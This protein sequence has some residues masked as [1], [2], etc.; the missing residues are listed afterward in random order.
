MMQ[1]QTLRRPAMVQKHRAVAQSL[2]APVG[3]WNA[4]DSLAD[5]APDDA[6]SLVNLYPGTTSVVLRDGF[7]KFAT[8]LGAQV[9]TVMSYE[10]AGTAKLFGI[11]GG[12][13][14]NC[15]A[16]GAV[17][18]AE[19]SGL[20][21]SRWQYVNISTAGGNF[22]EMCNGVDAV[23]T[24]DGSTW[25]D[26]SGNITGVTSSSLIGINLHKN[27]VWFVESGALKAWYLP[28]QSISGAAAV[29]DLRSFCVH[30][31]VLQAI[32]TWTIDAGYGV[33]DL[34]VGVTSEGEVLVYRGTD[35]SS[36]ST[37]ALVGI[38]HIGSPVGRRCMVKYAGDLLIICQDG[39]F[40]MASALQSSRTN[41]R[42]A[43]TDK[44][45]SAMSSAVTSYGA[46][47]GW[48]L[49][50]FP[51][52]NALLL[53]VPVTAGNSQQQYVMNTITKAWC[54]FR[55]WNA[56]VFELYNDDLY[57][58]GNTYVGKAWN[59]AEDDSGSLFIDGLQAFNYFG[60]RGQQKRFTM[61][62]PILAINST[63][64]INA[65]IN[66]NFDQS[67][68]TSAIGTAS[69]SGA[70]WD[71][72]TWDSATWSST[73]SISQSWQGATGV[74]YCG[75]PHIQANLDGASLQWLA[76]DV[77]MEPGGIV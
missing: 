46:N 75:A 71:T 24:Y 47:Y 2:P 63:Q 28:V 15:T 3:G 20:T 38:W 37:W 51:K 29:L 65:G 64:Q 19:L 67:A 8:G 32:G 56:N 52:H 14:Y 22:I 10:G 41:P 44:I 26:Q 5:M 11:A 73:S 58:G 34:W 31:G 4:R 57:F 7:S 36:A 16:G 55:G 76:T 66:V 54:A 61:L 43:L 21:N 9:E 33:D 12:N 62:R 39:V 72:G 1:R 53:N 48:Q 74:G 30:G 18:A 42:V 17:G 40:S 23:Y 49:M 45:Q 77:V 68:P 27:R 13:V 6:V 35:P 60:S 70:L 69:F 59:T 50:P 25:T